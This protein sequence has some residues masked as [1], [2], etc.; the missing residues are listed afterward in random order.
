LSDRLVP[1]G[2]SGE[3]IP[4]EEN[5]TAPPI[6]IEGYLVDDLDEENKD[7][8]RVHFLGPV[9]SFMAYVKCGET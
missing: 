6:R 1:G 3:I 8:Q 9:G 7:N 5:N 2:G 4:E